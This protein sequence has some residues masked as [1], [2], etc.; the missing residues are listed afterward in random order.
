MRNTLL[1]ACL[2]VVMLASATSSFAEPTQPV[3][4]VVPDVVL[5]DIGDG[6]TAGSYYRYSGL[7]FSAL[8]TGTGV[9]GAFYY[10]DTGTISINGISKVSLADDAAIIAGTGTINDL[11]DILAAGAGGDPTRGYTDLWDGGSD[12]ATGHWGLVG[13]SETLAD[14][15]VVDTDGDTAYQDFFITFGAPGTAGDEVGES[16]Y[17]DVK[18]D[19]ATDTDLGFADL[20]GPA[21]TA[22]GGA[23]T[24]ATAVGTNLQMQTTTIPP[25]CFNYAAIEGGVDLTPGVPD[26]WPDGVIKI[27]WV[28]YSYSSAAE[29][30]EIRA[31][32]VGDNDLLA[33][34]SG[35]GPGADPIAP[36]I[37]TDNRY[38]Q[39]EGLYSYLYY[40][41]Q[42]Q[43]GNQTGDLTCSIDYMPG[44]MTILEVRG[45]F[46]DVLVHPTTAAGGEGVEW[47]WAL[48]PAGHAGAG[49]AADYDA[50]AL[51]A[52]YTADAS[53]ISLDTAFT[54]AAYGSFPLAAGIDGRTTGAGWDTASGLKIT[55]GAECYD[56]WIGFQGDYIFDAVDGATYRCIVTYGDG[57]T[58]GDRTQ[59]RF[60][61]MIG[62]ANGTILNTGVPTVAIHPP[63]GG[64][65]YE[66]YCEAPQM[67]SAENT[68]FTFDSL[69]F[70]FGGTPARSAD[71]TLM[72]LKIQKILLP[73]Y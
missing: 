72:G 28:L 65:D 63:A 34:Q 31:R 5:G 62:E 37:R 69:D 55:E 38:G 73:G 57:L 11:K 6:Q 14:F 59:W 54:A 16:L 27:T 50:A 36:G 4:G 48:I 42:T 68:R 19:I 12:V 67:A 29:A 71:M 3:I 21:G 2:A 51:S 13:T 22:G 17:S 30:F 56:S 40:P 15:L 52:R 1:L 39:V 24:V 46:L 47:D 41:D 35:F 58:A 7:D 10:P 25:L 45:W 26:P 9:K 49:T 8:V 20:F 66:V 23:V 43:W 18:T 32:M 70:S 33:S 64:A 44:N 60:Q 53:W 61:F